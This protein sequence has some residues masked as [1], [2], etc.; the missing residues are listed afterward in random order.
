VIELPL[1][2]LEEYMGRWE[3][4]A[5]FNLAA[6]DAQSM[7][8]AELLALGTE[9]DREAFE[10]LS[11]GY[12]P[13]WGTQELLEAIAG[14][15]E[16]IDA[17]RVLTFAGA[18]EAMFWAMAELVGPGDHAMVTVPNYQSMESVTIATGAEVT[19]IRLDPKNGWAFDVDEIRRALRPTTR[20]IAVNAP[21]NPTG[22][23]PAHATWRDLVELCEE[24]GIRLFSDEVYR[25]IETD[26]SVT[27]PQ[28]ADLSPAAVS[29]GVLSKAYGMPGL[30]IGWLACRDRAL[31]ERLERRK[32]YTSICNAGPSEFLAALA[33]RHGERIRDRNRSIVAGNV[34][35]FRAL[36]ERWGG[37]L[38]W[39]P[40]QGGCVC[41]PRYLGGD[42][43][44][45]CRELVEAEGVILLP[46]S[47]YRSE[48][49]EVPDDRFRIGVGRRDPA[50]ALEALER[51]LRRSSDRA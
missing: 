39:D 20:L 17:S 18:E 43:E 13:T 16:H 8:I 40:P 35:E 22:A 4:A 45:F 7:T 48:L 38:G 30:R 51:F 34:P 41:F 31:L 14:T 24:R 33:L 10:R 19:A 21:N 2:R 25:G 44:A 27:L 15:Y 49:A 3:F 23:V 32:H 37:L 6:S 1:F 46:A 42:V 12:L 50:P 9:S 26:P 29:L 11:L 28:A 5:R 47:I 36:F